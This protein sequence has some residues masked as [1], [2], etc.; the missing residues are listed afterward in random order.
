M[1]GLLMADLGPGG[2]PGR[3]PDSPPWGLVALA[4]GLLAAVAVSQLGRR[5]RIVSR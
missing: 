1:V 4:A 2:R 5:R 3:G